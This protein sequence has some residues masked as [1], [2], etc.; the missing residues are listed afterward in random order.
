MSGYFS[1]MKTHADEMESSGQ[2]LGDEEFVAYVLTG[3]DEER[4]NA[5]V[6]S[7]V[8]RVEPIKP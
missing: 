3:L 4:Y 7:I 2:P 6:S 8:T 1:K 5:L